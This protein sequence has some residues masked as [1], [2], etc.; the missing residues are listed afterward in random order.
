MFSRSGG[1]T[2]LSDR[3]YRWPYEIGQLT[4]HRGADPARL[5][6]QSG[7]GTINAG[8]QLKQR[9]TLQESTHVQVRGQGAVSVH[10]ARSGTGSSEELELLLAPGSRLEL[11]QEPRILFPGAAFHQRTTAEVPEDSQLILVDAMVR[12]PDPGQVS[13]LSELHIERGGR[14]LVTER[15]GFDS[16]TADSISASALVIAAGIE[17][18]PEPWSDWLQRHQRPERYGSASALPNCAGTGVKI[19]A[20]DGRLLREGLAEALSILET[21]F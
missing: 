15:M 5:I 16:R 9:F 21:D 10:T 4:H 18:R 1:R 11:L 7:T 13:Y 12:H 8:D 6:V 2:V 20:A 19:V 14:A 17:H 3:L